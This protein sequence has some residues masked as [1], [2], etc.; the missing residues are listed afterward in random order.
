MSLFSFYLSYRFPIAIGVFKQPPLTHH[1]ILV[2]WFGKN[3]SLVIRDQEIVQSQKRK[4]VTQ[5]TLQ[6]A[7]ILRKGVPSGASCLHGYLQSVFILLKPDLSDHQEI[8]AGLF[9][10]MMPDASAVLGVYH[11]SHQSP[12]LVGGHLVVHFFH[13]CPG[14]VGAQPVARFSHF[15]SGI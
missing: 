3:Y 13:Q 11:L 12:G 9:S 4:W 5:M 8:K 6:F 1:C 2:T 15:Y 7:G 14:L 10:N